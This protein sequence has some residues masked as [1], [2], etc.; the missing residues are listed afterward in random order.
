MGKLNQLW[1]TLLNTYVSLPQVMGIHTSYLK[2]GAKELR[3]EFAK[4]MIVMECGGGASDVLSL[5]AMY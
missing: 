2:L 3:I 4:H 5:G 1:V